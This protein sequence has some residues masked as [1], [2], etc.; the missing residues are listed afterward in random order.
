MPQLWARVDDRLI[1]GQVVV[2][3]RQHLRYQAICVVDDAVRAD[4]VLCDVLR[5]ATP[6]GVALYICTT[7]EAARC[8]TLAASQSDKTLLLLKSPQVALRLLDEGLSLSQLNVGN[9]ASAPGSV[10]VLGAISLTRAHAAALDALDARGVDI[11]FQSTPDE[12]AVPWETLRRRYFQEER[13]AAR[14]Q[15]RGG[16]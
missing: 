9:L 14:A 11:T 12:P 8:A 4:P 3:W 10:R 7:E 6:S 2:G 13:K 5:L 1:H 16:R 15:G